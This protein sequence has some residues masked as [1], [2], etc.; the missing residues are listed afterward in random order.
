MLGNFENDDSNRFCYQHFDIQRVW[1]I[2]RLKNIDLC[3]TGMS[4]FVPMVTRE[5][6]IETWRL[7]SSLRSA[8]TT[9]P[10]FKV[11]GLALAARVGLT[12]PAITAAEASRSWYSSAVRLN[13]EIEGGAYT[14]SVKTD[15]RLDSFVFCF[16]SVVTAGLR[17][18]GWPFVGKHN[19]VIRRYCNKNG[20]WTQG[21]IVCLLS[22]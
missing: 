21:V 3:K 16:V 8:E 18:R 11:E 9:G 22:W 17:L 1:G 10:G 6:W 20:V 19:R 13:S 15:P 12:L 14:P 2:P 5:L 4:C 7:A